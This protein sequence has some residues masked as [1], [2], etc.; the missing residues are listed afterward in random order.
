MIEQGLPVTFLLLF[1]VLIWV[2]HLMILLS[3]PRNKVNQW[4]CLTGFLLSIGVWKEYIYYSGFFSGLQVYFMGVG[5]QVDELINSVLT[6]V[7]YYLA[8]PCGV[9]CSFYFSGTDKRRPELFRILRGAVFVPA[10]ILSI[11]YPWSQTRRIID[12]HPEAFSVVAVYNL[13]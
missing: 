9:I 5:Y 13:S 1:A 2:L 12:T 4:C 8:M 3:S 11:V 10:L 7:L 6:A